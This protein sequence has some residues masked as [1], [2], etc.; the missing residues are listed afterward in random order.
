MFGNAWHVATLFKIPVKVHWTFLL[1]IAYIIGYGYSEGAS[2][3]VIA[4]FL[5]AILLVFF[6]V[7]LHEFGH[8]LTARRY[9]VETEDIILLPIGGVARL[10]NLPDKPHQELIIAIMGPMVNLVIAIV[11]FA[12]LY[13]IEGQ[14]IFTNWDTI[15][16]NSFISLLPILIQANLTLIVFNM[17]PSFPMDGGRVL[18]AL[19]AMKFGKLVATKW[20]SIIGQIICVGF[21]AFGIYNQNY[22]LVIVGIFIFL[23]AKNEYNSVK[24]DYKFK[25][26]IVENAL[27]KDYTSLIEYNTVA[28]AE[29]QIVD[30]KENKFIVINLSGEQCGT[31]SRNQI[32]K[33]KK[34][35]PDLR[36][37]E[38]M[39]TNIQSITAE[40]PLIHAYYILMQGIDLLLVIKNNELIGFVDQ[41]SVNSAT[42]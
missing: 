39:N 12:I 34:S 15:N 3:K 17:I 30:V 6:C 29:S 40:M 33:N 8:A 24:I 21:I 11:L 31:I 14:Q 23:S 38:I 13:I 41:D 27:V 26:K 9:D 35:N 32:L 1:L 18:R 22:L 20:A 36:I 25:N 2:P 37:S 19:I 7:L 28:E 5:V 10:R 4:I 16:E 42:S